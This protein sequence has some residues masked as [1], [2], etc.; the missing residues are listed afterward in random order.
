MINKKKKRNRH[1]DRSFSEVEKS[2]EELQKALLEAGD[3]KIVG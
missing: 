2:L 1:V 3:Y